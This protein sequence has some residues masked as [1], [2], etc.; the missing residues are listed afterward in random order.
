MVVVVRIRKG[1]SALEAI[2]IDRHDWMVMNTAL[3]WKKT[4]NWSKIKALVYEKGL[5]KTF[6]K[7]K[8]LPKKEYESSYLVPKIPKV[9]PLKLGKRKREKPRTLLDR[10]LWGG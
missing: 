9:M 5:H 1:T 4:G 6:L 2:E 7:K 3:A 8:G 10:I